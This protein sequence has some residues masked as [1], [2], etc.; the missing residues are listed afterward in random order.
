MSVM[1]I[2]NGMRPPAQLAIVMTAAVPS[3]PLLAIATLEFDGLDLHVRDQAIF[4][5]SESDQQCLLALV[6]DLTKFVNEH[7][8]AK[9]LIQR[10]PSTGPQPAAPLNQRHEAALMVIKGIKA[11]AVSSAKLADWRNKYDPELPE[12]PIDL[13]S[14]QRNLLGRAYAAAAYAIYAEIQDRFVTCP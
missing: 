14:R 3:W 13:T 12:A 6:D 2:G 5:S 4:A 1:E 10:G 11:D 8:I 7:R 9:I